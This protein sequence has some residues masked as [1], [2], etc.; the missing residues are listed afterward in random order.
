[1][2]FCCRLVSCLECAEK[3]RSNPC[4]HQQKSRPPRPPSFGFGK[5]NTG[6]T[7]AA[8]ACSGAGACSSAFGLSNSGTA[9]QLPAAATAPYVLAALFATACP[10]P[11]SAAPSAA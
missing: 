1:M 5:A 10:A 4:N 9:P 2:I 6:C 8:Y 3:T 11:Q 7:F